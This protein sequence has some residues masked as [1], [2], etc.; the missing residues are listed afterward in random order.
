M[1]S[2]TTRQAITSDFDFVFNLYRQTLSTYVEQTWGHSEEFQRNR[3]R[4]DFETLPFEIVSYQGENIG[5]ISV[6]EKENK[7][8]IEFIFIA[9]NYQRQG[10]GT[11]L[12]NNILSRAKQKQ[13]PV[14]LNVIRINSAK[15]FYE[16]LGF[17][18][19]DSDEYLFSMEWR[20]Q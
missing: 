4:E 20:S 17:T 18:V 3:T 14:R 9:P 12:M 16:K 5:V 6:F 10:F 15:A 2:L 11:Q 8:F 7:L 13:I 19:I 1:N